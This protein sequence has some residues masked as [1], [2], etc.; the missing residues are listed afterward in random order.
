MTNLTLELTNLSLY[1]ELKDHFNYT[2]KWS[3]KLS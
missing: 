1:F 3:N 2:L